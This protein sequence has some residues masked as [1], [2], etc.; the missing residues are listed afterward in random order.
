M[1]R[2]KTNNV[3]VEDVEDEKNQNRRK[4]TVRAFRGQAD[5]LSNFYNIGGNKLHYSG[6]SFNS[7]EQAYQY[8]KA[9]FHGEKNLSK[10]ILH[11]T[12]P[13]RIKKLGDFRESVA[14][15]KEKVAFL[16]EILLR[17]A[18]CCSDYRAEVSDPNAVFVEAVQDPF[19][20]S[21]MNYEETCNARPGQWTGANVMGTLLS[22][23]RSRLPTLP[24]PRPTSKLKNQLN[25]THKSSGYEAD[26]PLADAESMS[27]GPETNT[28][29]TLSTSHHAQ[30]PNSVSRLATSNGN[31]TAE[32][33]S[34]NGI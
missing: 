34:Y 32:P 10:E 26:L 2:L 9:I 5:P 25:S 31:P 22:K 27:S 4:L 18:V 33:L 24:K 30:I 11:T 19:W 16:Q 1:G 20:G 28:K 7:S 3:C 23:I 6:K 21:G 17:K 12:D 14:W 8:T 13:R 15:K 29:P